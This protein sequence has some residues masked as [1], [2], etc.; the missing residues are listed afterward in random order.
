MRISVIG[1][2]IIGVACSHWLL[3]DGHEVTVF[4]PEPEGK[5]ASGGNAG[6]LALPE[7]HPLAS[8]DILAS[9]PNWLL[10]PLGPLSL[11]LRDLGSLAPWLV[12]F[13]ASAAPK[14][15]RASTVAL[16]NFMRT[17][18]SD[19]QTLEQR[20]G[21]DLPTT[22]TGYLAIY[23]SQ[24]QLEKAAI[25]AAGLHEMLGFSSERLSPHETRKIVPQLEGNFIGALLHPNY[26][27]VCDPY[28]IL[29]SLRKLLL[30][31]GRIIKS[32]VMNVNQTSLGVTVETQDGEKLVFDRTIIAAGVWSREIV[33]KTGLKVLLET[34]RGYNTTFANLDWRLPTPIDFAAHGFVA[35]QL[36]TG[37]RVGGAVELARPQAPPN[38]ARARALT[39]I[40]RRYVPSLPKNGGVEWMGCRPSTP[41]S[42]PVIGRH[43]SRDKI[44]FAFGHG[45]LGL[46]LSG[47][48]ARVISE[49]IAGNGPDETHN[50]FSIQRFQ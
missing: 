14:K 50:P 17:A 1:G 28:M 23:D 16:S 40:M 15:A 5:L 36:D 19:F 39:T 34:E 21:I 35:T 9:I 24:K 20:S 43:P 42:R 4:E 25:T 7:V 13:L 6:L 37:L 27:T 47:V 29:Q 32:R 38:Y 49:M 31:A 46:T 11:R 2:G 22:Q 41:D 26:H 12:A 10:D 33:R 45:H 48:T 44:L 3:A 18:Y 30:D 8:L